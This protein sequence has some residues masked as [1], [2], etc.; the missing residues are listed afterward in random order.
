MPQTLD[1]SR[2]HSRVIRVLAAESTRMGS[3][4]L[5]EALAQEHQ[6]EV[7]GVEARGQALIDAVAN[8]KPHVLLLS[9]T[10]EGSTTSGFEITRQLHSA[11]TD[12]KIVLLMDTATPSAVVEAFRSGAQGV[13]SRTE[14]S[15]AL[16][17]CISSVHQGQVWANSA[18]LRYLLQALREAPTMRMVDSRGD[19]ILSKREHDVVQCVA[20][21]LSN[22]EIAKRL[23]L[24][25]HTVKNYL[26]RIFD[27]LGVSSRVEVVL[28]AF[29]VRG[30]MGEPAPGS[31]R[32]SQI[33]N[34]AI[35]SQPSISSVEKRP[36]APVK[37]LVRRARV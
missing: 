31:P 32:A 36:A 34:T 2:E 24:T 25:E 28:Y 5:A 14:S 11:C 9:S 30:M 8:R 17:K 37:E 23:K 21:G 29:S 22:R 3:Q 10:L 33:A 4:L 35:S 7:S 16:A 20:E 13:F 12:T 19:E 15:K 26:F 18:E 6:F 1:V 27:K